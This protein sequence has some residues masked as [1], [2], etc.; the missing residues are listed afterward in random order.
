MSKSDLGVKWVMGYDTALL[1]KSRS[2]SLVS[3]TLAGLGVKEAWT[4]VLLNGKRSTRKEIDLICIIQVFCIFIA[5]VGSIS[6]IQ[7]LRMSAC[8]HPCSG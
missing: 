5:W 7:G 2:G 8:R 4:T 1:L 3:D 6:S